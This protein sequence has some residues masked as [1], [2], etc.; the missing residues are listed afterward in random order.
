[1]TQS[2]AVGDGFVCFRYPGL[3]V[4]TT[5]NA[6]DPA[7]E[8][9]QDLAHPIVFTVLKNVGKRVVRAQPRQYNAKT[10]TATVVY[11]ADIV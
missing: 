11:N 2:A 6:W 4:V 7:G 5:I 10:Q 9:I 8:P 3:G 1:M